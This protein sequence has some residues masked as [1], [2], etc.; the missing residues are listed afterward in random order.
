VHIE[1]YIPQSLLLPHCDLMVMH[2]GSN[3]LLAALDSG[4]PLVVVPLIADQ[5]FNAHIVQAMQL[6]RVVQRVHVVALT[7]MP[8]RPPARARN[9]R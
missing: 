6:G 3:S 4:L 5:F 8:G 7:S 9:S 2:G 1:R